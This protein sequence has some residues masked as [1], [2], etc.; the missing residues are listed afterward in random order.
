MPV[1]IALLLL[2]QLVGQLGPEPP[3]L[4]HSLPDLAEEAIQL[5][6]VV[7][8]GSGRILKL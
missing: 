7:R 5:A 6:A 3:G 4:S 1:V 8:G 2:A